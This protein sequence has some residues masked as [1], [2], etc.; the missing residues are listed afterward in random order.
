[1]PV[2][3]GFDA[4]RAIRSIEARRNLAAEKTQPTNSRSII[5]ALTGLASASD[6]AEAFIAGVDLYMAKPVSFRGVGK[7]LDDWESNGRGFLHKR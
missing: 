6:Q 4:T 3:N 2:L 1:M 5:I 7:L